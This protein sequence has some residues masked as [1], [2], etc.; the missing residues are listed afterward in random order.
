MSDERTPTAERGTPPDTRPIWQRRRQPETL[1]LRSF[2]PSFTV[3][4][5]EHSVDFYTDVLGFIVVERWTRDGVPVGAMLRAGDCE[6]SLVQDDGAKG[7]D[8]PRGQAMRI[9]GETGQDIDA[10]A[11][12]ARARGGRIVDGPKDHSW[13]ARGVSFDDPDGFHLTIYRRHPPP[14]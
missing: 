3:T 13:G 14:R 9:Y 4:E 2:T 6:L 7:R 11:E 1:R 12:R 8:R 10:L 5:L